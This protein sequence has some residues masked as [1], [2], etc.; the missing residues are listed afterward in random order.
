MLSE[1]MV[2]KDQAPEEKNPQGAE[3][4]GVLDSEVL[5]GITSKF[6]SQI[7]L[8]RSQTI[9]VEASE[10]IELKLRI[11]QLELDRQNTE[12]ELKA[13]KA[14]LED[15]RTTISCLETS[16]EREI[17]FNASRFAFV[18][19]MNEMRCRPGL[20]YK[21]DGAED[22]NFLGANPDANEAF[23]RQL[24]NNSKEC[25][26]RESRL[27]QRYNAFYNYVLATSHAAGDWDT[28]GHLKR[29][30]DPCTVWKAANFF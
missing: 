20:D 19:R 25:H 12:E 10:T 15:Q 26:K 4:I 30:F 6:E 29:E 2:N 13:C 17:S 14:Q 22:G 11:A 16:L 1:D 21:A 7:Q 27:Q 28:F 5:E 3:H 23:V 24:Y 9:D 8:G 18:H